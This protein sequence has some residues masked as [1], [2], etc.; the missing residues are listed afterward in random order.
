[1]LRPI[2]VAARPE[3]ESYDLI[4]RLKKACPRSAFPAVAGEARELL[5]ALSAPGPRS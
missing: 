4:V 3:I 5:A 2:V 1:M